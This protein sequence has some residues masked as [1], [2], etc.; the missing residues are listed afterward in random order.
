MRDPNDWL[1]GYRVEAVALLRREIEAEREARRAVEL[2]LMN[3]KVVLIGIGYCARATLAEHP[4]PT[5]Q[6]VS[7]DD[8]RFE[9]DG[10]RRG[11]RTICEAIEREL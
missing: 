7:L 3:L 2:Q 11:L 1:P 8:L 5:S 10:P 4:Q 9:R 6:M